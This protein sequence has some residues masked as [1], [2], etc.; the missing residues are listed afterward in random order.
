MNT[1][2][3]HLVVNQFTQCLKMFKGGIQDP[4]WSQ[5]SQLI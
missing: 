2:S 5:E 1:F 3:L 4:D